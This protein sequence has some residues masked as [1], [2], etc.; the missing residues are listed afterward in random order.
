MQPMQLHA[1]TLMNGIRQIRHTQIQVLIIKGSMG[2]HFTFTRNMQVCQCH[3]RAQ[4]MSLKVEAQFT[5]DCSVIVVGLQPS[6]TGLPSSLA[7]VSILGM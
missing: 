2:I 7:S 5:F 1:F 6:Y 4:G 3:R